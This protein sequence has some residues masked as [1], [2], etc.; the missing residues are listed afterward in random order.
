LEIDQRLLRRELENLNLGERAFKSP[1]AR[2]ESR[3]VVGKQTEDAVLILGK[4]DLATR[5]RCEE[6]ADP[7]RHAK[8][9]AIEPLSPAPGARRDRRAHAQGDDLRPG[10]PSFGSEDFGN[11]AVR[12]EPGGDCD[13][14]G[15]GEQSGRDHGEHR[16]DR[17]PGLHRVATSSE[18]EHEPGGD[19]DDRGDQP[20]Q[21]L[22]AGQAAGDLVR[23][24]A[25]L[26]LQAGDGAQGARAATG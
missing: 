21:Q 11:G 25:Q 19:A 7:D 22:G 24:G 9:V 5:D 26:F 6:D 14:D 4:Q 2:V 13:E 17:G 23:G 15:D 20:G 1:H 3:P 12:A 10:G 16:K 8:K 18:V